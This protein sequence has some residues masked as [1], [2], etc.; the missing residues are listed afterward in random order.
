MTRAEIE[1]I[2]Q[3]QI[4]KSALGRNFSVWTYLALITATLVCEGMN[5]YA[6]R[7]NSVMMTIGVLMTLATAGFLGY[8][9]YLLRELTAMDHAD[10]SLLA[11][12][13]RRL[14]FHRT[15]Y[16]IWLW[17]IALTLVFLTLAVTTLNDAQ[18]GEYRINRPVVFIGFTLGQFLLMYAVLKLGQYPFVRESKAILS[19]LEGQVTTGTDQIKTFK[20]TW[21]WWMLLLA[22][23]G[24]VLLIWGICKAIGWPG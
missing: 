21:R 20:R 9:I 1:A 13:Q 18:E 23:L 17:M 22:V 5:I 15:K 10:E 14:R 6:F 12:L 24:A 16:E 2:L 4:R 8:G 11:K 7:A 3:P 19:D